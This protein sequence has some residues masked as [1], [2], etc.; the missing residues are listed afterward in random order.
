M[1]SEFLEH[2]IN[3]GSGKND[4]LLLVCILIIFSKMYES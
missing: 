2:P 4:K 1:V 3:L